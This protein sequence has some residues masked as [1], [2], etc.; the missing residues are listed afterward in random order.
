MKFIARLSLL[1]LLTWAIPGY[2]DSPDHDA[3]DGKPIQRSVAPDSAGKV[4]PPAASDFDMGRV[5]LALFAVVGLILL[6]RSFGKKFFPAMIVGGEQPVRVLS[7]CPI[8]PR[9]QVLLL[10]VGRRI[11]VA[12]DS[13]SQLSCLTQITD[14]DEVA[15]LLGEL[16]RE[17]SAPS[18]GA[19]NSLFAKAAKSFGLATEP[20]PVDEEESA[21]PTPTNA[22]LP[23]ATES[24]PGAPPSL[25]DLSDRIR[26]LSHRLGRS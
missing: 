24:S 7:R 1:L 17:R 8:S 11:V 21:E 4:V 25:A 19:F 9:Q 13:N 23:P 12:A 5:V 20:E 6:L 2:A 16:R 18:S 15:A 22:D 10:Q 14:P 3:H 26:Q